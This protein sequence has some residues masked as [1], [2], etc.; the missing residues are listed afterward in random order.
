MS[1]DPVTLDAPEVRTYPALA[2]RVVDLDADAG[3][4]ELHGRAVPYQTESNVGWYLE[5]I[6][7]GAFDK[8]IKEAAR[9][10]PLLLWHDNR[11]WPIG[12]SAD[13]TSTNEGLDGVW[14]LDDSEAAQR[15]GRQARDGF[16]VGM[17]VGF[18]PIKS[19][20]A[21]VNDEQWMDG[22]RD[23]VTRTEAR[24]LEVSLTPTPAYAGAQVALVRSR[25]V[26]TQVR[27]H[28]AAPG[29]PSKLTH[30]RDVLD[31]IRG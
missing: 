10:L 11:S 21:I 2:L 19:D 24:L 22:E 8:S 31:E 23:T 7:K 26:P 28:Q 16:M 14:E 17:S 25:D 5:K 6:A 27:Q 29:R 12:R 13:W 20:W 4:S 1:T 3:L 30:W 9:G 18:L 15:A